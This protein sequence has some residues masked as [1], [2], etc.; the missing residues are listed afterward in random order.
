ME[1]EGFLMLSL[2][3]GF[4][5]TLALFAFVYFRGLTLIAAFRD[6]GYDS[7]KLLRWT[8]TGRHFEKHA[9]LIVLLSYIGWA[10]LDFLAPPIANPVFYA[11]ILVALTMSAF[12][13]QRGAA[14]LAKSPAD[15]PRDRKILYLYLVLTAIYFAT[16]FSAGKEINTLLL[17][18]SFLAFLQAPPI[19]IIASNFVLRPFIK[20]AE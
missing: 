13:D 17:T 5:I 11:F 12:H 2:I 10:F 4:I 15:V 20:G 8:I 18:V 9:T 14:K 3:A 1:N 19:F 16:L 7:M 6:L